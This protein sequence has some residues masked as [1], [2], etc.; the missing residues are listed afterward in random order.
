M[1]KSERLKREG[2]AACGGVTAQHFRRV[3]DTHLRLVKSD[4]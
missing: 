3:K 4:L 1:C 2:G